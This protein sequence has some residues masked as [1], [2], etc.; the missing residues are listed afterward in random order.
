MTGEKLFLV[1]Y[2]A[3]CPRAAEHVDQLIV[4]PSRATPKPHSRMIDRSQNVR[5]LA[6]TTKFIKGRGKDR[7]P[8]FGNLLKPRT[9][10]RA[11]RDIIVSSF[12]NLG[13]LIRKQ[14]TPRDESA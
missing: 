2:R 9:T 11:T 6:G 4:G 10:S 13:K 1:S 3:V 8:F 12:D 5:K 7:Q 14:I